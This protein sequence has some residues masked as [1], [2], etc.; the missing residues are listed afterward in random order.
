MQ[1]KSADKVISTI[2]KKLTN[3]EIGKG[4]AAYFDQL[5]I[6]QGFI[7]SGSSNEQQ[8][9]KV[10]ARILQLNQEDRFGQRDY[11]GFVVRWKV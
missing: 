2:A 11:E 7:P 5:A 8:M 4:L 6:Q 3:E 1:V 10:V 9:Q